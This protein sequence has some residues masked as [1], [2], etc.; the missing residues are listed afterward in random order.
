MVQIAG[1]KSN[2]IKQLVSVDE[3]GNLIISSLNKINVDTIDNVTE[4]HKAVLYGTDPTAAEVPIQCNDEGQLNTGRIAL[5]DTVAEGYILLNANSVANSG[6]TVDVTNTDAERYDKYM[7]G[8]FNS[9]VESTINVTIENL[10]TTSIIE[11][12]VRE[13]VYSTT[14]PVAQQTSFSATAW[15]SCFTSIGGV[16][17]DE[18]GDLNDNTPPASVD[19]PFP[20]AATN[21]AIYFGNTLPFYGLVLSVGT[22]GVYD[23]TFIWEYWNGS[24]WTT[25]T[26]YPYIGSSTTPWKTTG[27][28]GYTFNAPSN[29]AAYDIAGSPTSQYW[30]RARVSAFTSITTAPS[31]IQGWY[32]QVGYPQSKMYIVEGLFNQ[33]NNGRIAIRNN[34]TLTT[35]VPHPIF[36]QVR[37]Y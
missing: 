13:E 18:S 3:N 14:L 6:Y 36:Y 19:V 35:G 33:N 26:L 2:K 15:S 24:A 21:D 30:L 28:K 4:V 16:L 27:W 5:G 23:A 1:Q 25:I 11:I 31:F 37:K 9:A 20:F 7:V 32:Q 22:A 10:T 12:P 29:W 17:V 8:F 34:T